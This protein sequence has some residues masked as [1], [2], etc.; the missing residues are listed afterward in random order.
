VRQPP[1]R[2]R[3][4]LSWIVAVALV[5][6]ACE[7][8][9]TTPGPS[10][11]SSA[12]T[13]SATVGASVLGTASPPSSSAPSLQ[14]STLAITL[15][16]ATSRGVAFA[17]GESILLAGGLTAT[18][19]TGAIY[20]I[21]VSDGLVALEGQLAR[22][23]HDA[24]GTSVEGTPMVFGGGNLEPERG[25]QQLGARHDVVGELPLPRADLVVVSIDDAAIVVGGGTPARLDR[26]VLSTTDGRHFQA[27]ATLPVGVRYPA[28]AVVN[29]AIYVVGGTDG[30]HDRTEIETIDPATGSVRVI[31]HL[32]HG[33]AHATA[34]V[35]AG[36]LLICGGRAG[37]VAQDTIWEVDP[38][39][40]SI[41]LEGHLPQ[42]VS[43]A[44][45]VVVG[46]VAYL[47]GGEGR[48]FLTSIVT[49]SLG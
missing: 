12:T 38:A 40:G 47:I 44:A 2:T 4:P 28:V 26:A 18:G 42:G 5:A 15:R 34:F 16:Q 27:L 11:T 17:D 33:L 29:G 43:D 25:V 45:G 24:G 20:R 32:D 8:A 22:A 23:V 37:G 3:A 36:R 31:G 14:V 1:R 19:T 6:V 49:I 10:P 30:V 41:R 46:G 7:P 13:P 39:R 48:D 21:S 35:L 9:Q